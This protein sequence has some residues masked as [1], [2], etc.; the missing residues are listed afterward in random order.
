MGIEMR[1]ICC[2]RRILDGEDIQN[3][4][5]KKNSGGNEKYGP[6]GIHLLSLDRKNLL[7]QAVEPARMG[8]RFE[9]GHLHDGGSPIEG[10]I[11]AKGDQGAEDGAEDSALTDMEP[12]GFNFDDRDG[13]IALKIHV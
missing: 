3:G 2:F 12:I 10:K 9:A 1:E 7:Q 6:G 11:N 5:E 8:R 4:P 13:A